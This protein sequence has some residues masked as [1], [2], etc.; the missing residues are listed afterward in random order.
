M[1]DIIV[2]PSMVVELEIVG[3]GA[4]NH[5]S[6]NGVKTMNGS[7]PAPEPRDPRPFHYLIIDCSSIPF[8]DN[9][10]AKVLKQVLVVVM[11]SKKRDGKAGGE[12]RAGDS[13]TNGMAG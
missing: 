13:A 4:A 10:G 12:G 7:T 11:N 9:V 6:S 1:Q 3:P 8:V 2:D 5:D